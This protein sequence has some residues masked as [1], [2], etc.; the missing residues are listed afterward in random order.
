MESVVTLNGIFLMLFYVPIMFFGFFTFTSLVHS[1]V[2][3]T[4]AIYA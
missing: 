1:D 4:I 2:L 3:K